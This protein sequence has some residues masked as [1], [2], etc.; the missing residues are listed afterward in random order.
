MNNSC[1]DSARLFAEIHDLLSCGSASRATDL[2]T[3][4]LLITF[5]EPRGIPGEVAA[6][7]PGRTVD[8]TVKILEA[9]VSSMGP[10][11]PRQVWGAAKADEEDSGSG[12]NDPALESVARASAVADNCLQG[13]EAILSWGENDQ[14]HINNCA[15]GIGLS[16]TKRQKHRVHAR[17][18]GRRITKSSFSFEDEDT[19]LIREE[20]EVWS[21]CFGIHER[22]NACSVLSA[23]LGQRSSSAE[24]ETAI[25]I[26]LTLSMD[27][28][29]GFR[30][31]TQTKLWT[32]AGRVAGSLVPGASTEEVLYVF[33]RVV[34]EWQGSWYLRR[35]FRTITQFFRYLMERVA[36]G[37]DNA[38]ALLDECIAYQQQW[39]WMHA[40]AAG[41]AIDPENCYDNEFTEEVD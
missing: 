23:T 1:S 32:F 41:H 18:E 36:E 2:L 19:A 34:E 14:D 9:A 4:Y 12:D 22:R 17:T 20:L 37:Q 35:R 27:I 6:S 11:M 5:G 26:A 38:E 21:D 16:Q 31:K 24:I 8:E 39:L 10:K 25:Q 40:L 3:E 29:G 13:I 7:L 15:G 30:Y 28:C 33:N